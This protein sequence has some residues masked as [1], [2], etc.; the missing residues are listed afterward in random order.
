MTLPNWFSGKGKTYKTNGRGLAPFS[1]TVRSFLRTP[2]PTNLAR[3][4]G[5]DNV[6]TWWIILLPICFLPMTLP[7]SFSGKGKTYKTNRR[8]LTPFSQTVRSLLRT[9][10][11]AN[12]ARKNGCD[13]VPTWWIILLPICYLPMTLPN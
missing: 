11:L 6:P 5:C 3:K 4:N 12:L 10:W 7:N 13:N 8:G 2:E 1:Q 9:P